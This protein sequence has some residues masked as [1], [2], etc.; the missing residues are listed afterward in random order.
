MDNPF[1]KISIIGLGLI[2][3]SIGLATRR[4]D[5]KIHIQG[6][7]KNQSTLDVAT[8]RG[9][10]DEAFLNLRQIDSDTDLVILAS[11]LSTFKNIVE[12]IL[13]FLKDDCVIT[14]TGSA[15]CRV[16]AEIESILPDNLHFIPGHPIAGTEMSGPESGFEELFD[17]RWCILTPSKNTNVHKLNEIKIFWE[18]LGAMIEI[19][20]P[21]YHDKVLAITSHLP[22]LIAFTIVGT[23][24]DLE[25]DLKNDVIRFSASGFRDFTRIAASDP[26][27]WRDVFLNN[28]EAVLEMLQRFTEDLAFLQKAINQ[29]EGDK[30][31]N[32]FKR[33]GEIRRSIIDIGFAKE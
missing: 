18:N 20:D 21:I 15:K 2:G 5:K 7:A 24:S 11:P 13:P 12:E 26:T 17:N 14:D 22:H 8:S 19:M 28:D 31:L 6:F 23:A 10:V 9:F 16:I 30:L 33:T 29:R 1:K 25:H 3:G 32:L 4:Y 27:M